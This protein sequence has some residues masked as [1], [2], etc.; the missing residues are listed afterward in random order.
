MVIVL[1][2]SS[3]GY[4]AD[5][6][7]RT[8]SV[9]YV[10]YSPEKGMPA[11]NARN[12]GHASEQRFAEDVRTRMEGFRHLLAD[13]FTA[14]AVVDVRE[15]KQEMSRNYDVTVFDALPAP[16][17]P[18]RDIRDE[19]GKYLRTE[20]ER[21]LDPDFDCPA[22]FIAHTGGIL[23]QGLD[24]KIDWCCLCLGAYAHHVKTSH[25][26][27]RR[28]FPVTLSLEQRPTPLTVYGYLNGFA[29]PDQIPMWKVQTS[30]YRDGKG[31]RIGLVSFGDGFD[32]SPDAEAIAGGESL[33]AVN[34]VSIGRHGNFLLWGFAASPEEL[35]PEART[36]FA[37]CVA[38]ISQFK[39][40]RPVMRKTPRQAMTTR[41]FVDEL[42]WVVS[43]DGYR[44]YVHK[45]QL[46]DADR[47]KQRLAAEQRL[48]EKGE[49][50]DAK[51]L[52]KRYGGAE[53]MSKE[54]F[55]T[56]YL[57]KELGERAIKNRWECQKYILARRPYFYGAGT[58]NRFVIDEDVARLKIANYDQ[59]LLEKCISL[60]ERGESVELARRLLVR[61]TNHQFATAQEWRGWY[62]KYK[63]V[64][65]FT[66]VGGYKFLENVQGIE[67][68]TSNVVEENKPVTVSI[69]LVRKEGRE[70]VSVRFRIKEGYH[71]YAIPTESSPFIPTT[72]TFHWPD[73]VTVVGKMMKPTAVLQEGSDGIMVYH[74][75]VEFLQEIAVT[76][77]WAIECTVEYQCC[78]D[79]ICMPP[80][81]E[82]IM[83]EM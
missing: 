30:G 37:N 10:G 9:L 81:K 14:V 82:E 57:G 42:L 27:F 65:F 6:Q 13:Y 22:V 28:P 8:M 44:Q 5:H 45:R 34:A 32:D 77:K 1:C 2:I 31:Q 36:V 79:M 26:V 12:A 38:Y 46:M 16:V 43:V 75:K 61:Y 67:V 71:I 66:E 11:Y 76:G 4:A 29:E 72:L 18:A 50:V 19:Q 24:L 68:E 17:V 7:K 83:C 54:A 3:L 52:D 23:Q 56:A 59:R 70:F 48:K 41:S 21:Y 64:L 49:L 53:I 55:Y 73:G 35:T 80:V 58:F 39:G 62:E 33:K 69:Q 20:G 74:G 15:Y 25:E 40:K 51:E 60:W 78:D 63:K 47:Q